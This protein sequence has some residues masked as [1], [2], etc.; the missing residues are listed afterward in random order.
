MPEEVED[1]GVRALGTSILLDLREIGL[2][3]CLSLGGRV[4]RD[5]EVLSGSES[6]V[7]CGSLGMGKLLV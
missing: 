6:G 5:F 7:F 3:F 2:Y 4:H 1:L